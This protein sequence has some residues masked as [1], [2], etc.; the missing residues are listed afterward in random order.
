MAAKVA[1]S[2]MPDSAEAAFCVGPALHRS[3]IGINRWRGL[4]PSPGCLRVCSAFTRWRCCMN[5]R[6]LFRPL[7]LR[8]V[9]GGTAVSALAVGRHWPVNLTCGQR[10]ALWSIAA[11]PVVNVARCCRCFC[12]SGRLGQSV[13]YA[14]EIMPNAHALFGRYWP[15]RVLVSICCRSYVAF[16]LEGPG[17]SFR[18]PSL[19]SRWDVLA[20]ALIFTW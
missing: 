14:K 1:Y 12:C 17:I 8:R 19:V 5:S 18:F 11:G 16:S 9:G 2:V 20:A 4:F 6:S 3:A 13:G 15:R 7:L 10:H